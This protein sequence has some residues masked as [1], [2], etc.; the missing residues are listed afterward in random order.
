MKRFMYI[1]TAALL[2]SGCSSVADESVPQTTMTG[3]VTEAVTSTTPQQ[4]TSISTTE[5]TT[6]TTSVTYLEKDEVI[7][8]AIQTPKIDGDRLSYTI[9]NIYADGKYYTMEVS[10]IKLGSDAIEDIDNTYINDELYGDFRLELKHD[11][12]LIDSLKINIPRDD[13]FLIL[14][15]AK[16]SFS[17][18]SELISNK[19]EFKTD[20]YPD[21]LQLDFYMTDETETPQYARY[22]AVYDNKIEEL[23]VLENGTEVAPHGTHLEFESE[24]VL[25]QHVVESDQYGNYFVQKYRYIFNAQE[26]YLERIR[27]DY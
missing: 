14:E 4:T 17:Y 27:V 21:L 9:I 24:G 19:R 20:E 25:T 15:S 6:V 7:P 16:E 1:T 26:H 18:G 2:L 12:E 23:P 3:S 11:G 5:K 22:F 13:R 8:D 10:G